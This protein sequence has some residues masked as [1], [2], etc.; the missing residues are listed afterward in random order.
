MS[1]EKDAL[2]KLNQD[3]NWIVQHRATL[4]VVVAFVVGFILGRLI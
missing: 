1:D 4:I 2:A 3:K